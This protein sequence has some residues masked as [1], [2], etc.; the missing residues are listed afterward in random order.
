M[1]HL[2]ASSSADA[3]AAD[4]RRVQQERQ[5]FFIAFAVME[6]IVLALA[7]VLIYVLELIDPALGHWVL[8]AIALLGGGILSTY[9]VISMRPSRQGPAPVSGAGDRSV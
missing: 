4:S 9:L 1:N 2:P 5:R 6:G 7:A 3:A 8:I